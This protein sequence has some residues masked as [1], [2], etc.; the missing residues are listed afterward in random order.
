MKR[1]IT[2]VFG[3]LILASV[4]SNA[5]GNTTIVQDNFNSYVDGLGNP[6]QAAFEANWRPDNGD[7]IPDVS[8]PINAGFLVPD[9]YGIVNPPNNNPPGLDGVGVASLGSGINESRAT[10][11]LMPSAT[12]SIRFGGDIFNDGPGVNDSASGMRQTIALRNDNYDRDPVAFGC[13]CGTNFIELGFYNTSAVDPITG[14][15]RPNTQF[16]FRIALF[17]RVQPGNVALPNWLSFT[18]DPALDTHVGPYP[19]ADYNHG[20]KVDAADYVLWREGVQ[21]LQHE[22]ADPIGTT[23]GAD[24]TAWRARFGNA[25]VDLNDIGAGWHRYSA[26]IKPDSITV[27]LDLYR[28]GINNAT[29]LPGVD[30]SETWAAQMDTSAGAAGAFNSLRIGPPSGISGNDHTVFDNV[31]LTVID[32]PGVGTSLAS[33]PEPCSLGLFAFGAAGLL[34][35]IQPRRKQTR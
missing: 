2:L 27:E 15:T 21:P 5:H 12:Q 1:I 26:L 28:D 29:G 13:Q 34:G 6:D 30:V 32:A 35:L 20:G 14:L 22:V 9:Q 17:S 11:S 31:F 7:G 24:Y 8:D 19:D 18:L 10:F 25:V 4:P 16:Q 33:V 3:L 23:D